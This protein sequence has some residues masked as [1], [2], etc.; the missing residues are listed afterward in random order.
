LNKVR[1]FAT[2]DRI[3]Q[4][5]IHTLST[6]DLSLSTEY[7]LGDPTFLSVP[8]HPPRVPWRYLVLCNA[9]TVYCFMHI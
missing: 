4:T 6:A 8:W 7:R 1:P 5:E 3:T 2:D 9:P